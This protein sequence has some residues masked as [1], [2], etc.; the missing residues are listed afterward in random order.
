M[1]HLGDLDGAMTQLLAAGGL[2]YPDLLA[3]GFDV[4]PVHGEPGWSG[5]LRWPDEAEVAVRLLCL[6]QTVDVAVA[7]DGSGSRPIPPVLRQGVGPLETRL[8]CSR[9]A[10]PTWSPPPTEQPTTEASSVPGLDAW[11]GG[12]HE[13]ERLTGRLLQLAQ[14]A[15]AATPPKAPGLETEGLWNPELNLAV[16][17]RVPD[18]NLL[19]LL[20]AGAWLDPRRP[21]LRVQASAPVGP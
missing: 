1:W 18:A 4:Q 21:G 9:S 11:P 10:A 19:A 14:L 8:Y 3:A 13:L 7:T 5:S 17:R 12:G 6:G 20:D 16:F 15:A 2:A